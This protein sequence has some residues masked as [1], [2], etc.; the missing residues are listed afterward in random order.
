MPTLRFIE[1][2]LPH[3]QVRVHSFQMY[4]VYVDWTTDETNYAF[5]VGCG[6]KHR[7]S[8]KYRNMF[9]RRL[10]QKHGFRREI[11]MG[12][13][14]SREVALDEEVRLIKILNTFHG[15]NPRGA[16]FTRG[17]EGAPGHAVTM[18]DEWRANIAA[19]LRGR[20][21]DPEANLKRSKTQRGRPKNRRPMTDDERRLASESRRGKDFVPPESRERQREKLRGRKRPPFTEEHRQ[22]LREAALRNRA[23][24]G[25]R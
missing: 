4:Y 10:A 20:P 14:D 3:I 19:A 9:H 2:I 25:A 17:G 6:N 8:K 21:S 23:G 13:V 11:V 18:T 7:T 24:C 16:N 5:Y 22:R 1:A 15:D 12:P